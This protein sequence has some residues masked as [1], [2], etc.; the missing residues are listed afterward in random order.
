MERRHVLAGAV[1][2]SLGFTGCLGQLDA[3]NPDTTESSETSHDAKTG[4]ATTTPELNETR[5]PVAWQWDLPRRFFEKGRDPRVGLLTSDDWR[6]AVGES[7]LSTEAR[8]FLSETD[9]D[10]ETVVAF[11]TRVSAGLNRL[12]LNFVDGVGTSTVTLAV[13][14]WESRSGLNNSPLHLLLVRVPNQDVEPTVATV[15][16]DTGEE[17]TTVSTDD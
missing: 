1:A 2:L 7:V 16:L 10:S 4:T 9:F 12:V 3:T 11:E 6:D 14:E 5:Y 15:H 8:S 13:E 17:T